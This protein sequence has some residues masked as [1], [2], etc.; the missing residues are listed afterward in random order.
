MFI[1]IGVALYIA[2]ANSVRKER[3]FPVKFYD[4]IGWAFNL[5]RDANHSLVTIAKFNIQ[6]AS[7]SIK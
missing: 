2:I 5:V 7:V 4:G 1:C 3:G 6:K